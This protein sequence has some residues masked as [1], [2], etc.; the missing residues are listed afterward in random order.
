MHVTLTTKQN[1]QLL[2]LFISRILR[3]FT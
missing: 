2:F 1:E 3:H